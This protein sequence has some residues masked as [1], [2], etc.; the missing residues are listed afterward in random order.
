MIGVHKDSG[1]C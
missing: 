1:G